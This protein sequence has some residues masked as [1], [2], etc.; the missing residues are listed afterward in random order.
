MF[1]EKKTTE[2][3]FWVFVYNIYLTNLLFICQSDGTVFIFCLALAIY[4]HISNMYMLF[5][6][7]FLYFNSINNT[8]SW[9]IVPLIVYSLVGLQILCFKIKLEKK[10]L[11]IKLREIRFC[12]IYMYQP[13]QSIKMLIDI[14][15]LL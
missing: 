10:I 6:T 12:H 5:L 14:S 1:I 2:S 3:K 8:M 7:N 13:Y 4:V 9:Y 11:M 15:S